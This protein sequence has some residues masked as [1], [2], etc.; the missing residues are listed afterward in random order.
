M[1]K[2]II[3]VRVSTKRQGNSGLSLDQQVDRC[4]SYIESQDGELIGIYKDIESGRSRKRLGLREAV[5][6]C[7]DTG[8]TLVIAKL[9]RL[10]R[11]AEFAFNIVNSGIGIYFCD[12]PQMN[13]FLLGIFASYAQY[14]AEKISERVKDALI[15][16]RKRGIK[17][18]AANDKY[19]AN[20]DID[21]HMAK[22]RD[23]SAE[24]RAYNAEINENNRRAIA[25]IGQYVSNG[26]GW[27]DIANEL[28]KNNFRTSTGA[29]FTKG[30]AYNTYMR[31]K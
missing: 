30:S 31:R 11:D 3:Y 2:Y 22:C 17:M 24:V 1:N 7:K 14:E 9:D 5:N 25:M 12:F 16:V 15:Q 8:A 20:V 10:A 21:L 23:R 18:G 13:T 27:Q 4:K 28:N 26:K 19:K 29:M 6:Y